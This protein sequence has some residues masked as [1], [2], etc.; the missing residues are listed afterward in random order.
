VLRCS[1]ASKETG[2]GKGDYALVKRIDAPNNRLT[3]GLQDGTERTYDPRRQ[4]GVSVFR[5]ETRGFSV[6]DRVQFTAPANDL[7]VA[8]RE[9]GTIERIVENG[10][11][12]L[13]MDGGREVELEL[14]KH[15][16]LDHGYAMTSHSSQGQTADRVVIHVDTELGANDLLNSRMAYVSVSR[17]RYDA[18]IYTDNA[19]T[20]GQELSRD[21]SHSP[22]IPQEPVSQEIETQ[23]G[24]RMRS[25]RASVLVCDA[26]FRNDMPG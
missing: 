10:R 12:H 9:L 2:I 26:R 5:E 4:Q 25:G 7:K 11:L 13:R 24:Q 14:G 16:H 3:V 17:G 6:G 18:Q 19:A 8:N 15:P 23:T 22:A 1:R 21:V 20:L